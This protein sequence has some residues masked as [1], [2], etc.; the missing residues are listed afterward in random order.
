M[1]QLLLICA[2]HMKHVC[3]ELESSIFLTSS[4]CS[5]DRVIYDEM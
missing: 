1:C 4:E 3:S 2:T 5:I